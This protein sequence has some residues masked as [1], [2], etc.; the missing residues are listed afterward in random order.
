MSQGIVLIMGVT[1]QVGAY[2][3][4]LLLEPYQLA[5]KTAGRETRIWH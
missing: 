4:R 3:A 5:L 1:G 2:L